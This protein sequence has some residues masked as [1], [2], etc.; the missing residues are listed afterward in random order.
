MVPLCFVAPIAMWT[1]YNRGYGA[2]RLRLALNY[3]LIALLGCIAL[4]ATVGSGGRAVW[5]CQ[6]AQVC[7]CMRALAEC[8]PAQGMCTSRRSTSVQRTWAWMQACR[9]AG[10]LGLPAC[11]PHYTQ[12]A[13]RLSLT[14]CQWR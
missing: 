12:V 8:F 9:R 10:P 6:H 5:L 13:L 4:A 7:R 1:S 2:S 3:A 11:T 14:Q